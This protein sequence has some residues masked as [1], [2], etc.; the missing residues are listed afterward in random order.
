[1]KTIP[2]TQGKFAIVDDEDYEKIAKN[3]WYAIQDNYT[4]YAVRS[5]RKKKKRKKIRMHRIIMNAPQG[6][7]VDHI[8]GNGLKNIK[9]N[10]RFATNSQQRQNSTRHRNAS[11]K[12]KGVSFDN[13]KK[14]WYSRTCIDYKRIYIGYFKDETEAAIAYDKKAIELFGKFARLN[15]LEN[16]YLSSLPD[17]TAVAKE[18]C[19]K[20]VFNTG[21]AV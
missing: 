9:S 2:L 21:P 6:Q 16:P 1:M 11:S 5:I 13:N 20:P 10:L 12:F 3:K 15:I 8:N 14:L 7:Q 18:R 4:F 17:S 19:A